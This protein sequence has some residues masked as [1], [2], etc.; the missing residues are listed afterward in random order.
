MVTS[1]IEGAHGL[2]MDTTSISNELQQVLHG[3]GRRHANNRIKMHSALRYTR[4]V[5]Y[6]VNKEEEEAEGQKRKKMSGKIKV[7]GLNHNRENKSDLRLA[8]EMFHT[9]YH[10]C[11]DINNTEE[12]NAALLITSISYCKDMKK[13][14]KT[15]VK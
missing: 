3:M 8:L 11:S 13:V 2:P 14:T 9:I 15:T 7:S 5:T 10:M 6:L 12:T 4:R 1:E